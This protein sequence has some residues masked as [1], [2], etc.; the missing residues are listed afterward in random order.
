M[1]QRPRRVLTTQHAIGKTEYKTFEEAPQKKKDQKFAFIHL[2][3][4][5]FGKRIGTNYFR[6]MCSRNFGKKKNQKKTTKN[7][8]TTKEDCGSHQSRLDF[9]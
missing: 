9:F 7:N 5:E 2:G 4:N 1:L 8:K 3:R 6:T